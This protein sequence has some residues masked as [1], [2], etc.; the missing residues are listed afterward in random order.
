ME[1]VLVNGKIAVEHGRVTG[2]A[3][4]R[5][6]RRGDVGNRDV[7]KKTKHKNEEV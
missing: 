7:E 5:V 3:G 2:V 6:I 1:Y 4:G